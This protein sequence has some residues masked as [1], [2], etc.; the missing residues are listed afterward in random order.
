[1]IE[2]QHV[3]KIYNAHTLPVYAL[4]DVSLSISRS[5][6]VAL[7][8]SSGSGKT[9]LLNILSAIDKPTRGKV[10][11]DGTDLT[12]MTERQLTLF[13]RRKIGIIFQF[14]NLMPTL[15]VLENV[16]LPSSLARLPEK[17]M[18]ERAVMLLERVGL[19]H[20]LSHQPFQLSGGEMQR[21][22]IARA[23]MNNPD[24]I[25]ADEPTGNLDSKN[26]AQILELVQELAREEKKTFIIATH[27]YDVAHIADRIITLRDGKIVEDELVAKP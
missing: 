21:T 8:G 11:V 23:L 13:R 6:L 5:E 9:T 25:I 4:S 20:R 27:S 1:M 15:T 22:A 14:F 10:I 16:L 24:L 18:R 2:L 17:E 12:M 7:M 26:A 19:R 3:E